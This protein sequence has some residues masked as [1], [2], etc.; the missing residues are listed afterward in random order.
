M[1]VLWLLFIVITLIVVGLTSYLVSTRNSDRKIRNREDPILLAASV[2]ATIA[3]AAAAWAA[4]ATLDAIKTIAAKERRLDRPYILAEVLHALAT[5]PRNPDDS[6]AHAFNYSISAKIR[7]TNIGRRDAAD[8]VARARIF[9]LRG[10]ALDFLFS[11]ENTVGLGHRS[12]LQ[13]HSLAPGA[14]HRPERAGR[15]SMISASEHTGGVFIFA[16]CVEYGDAADNA[17]YRN[18]Q[19]FP[20]WTGD[21]FDDYFPNY[22]TSKN[23]EYRLQVAGASRKEKAVTERAPALYEFRDNC[24][25]ED[26]VEMLPDRYLRFATPS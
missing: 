20:L 13:I 8:I 11:E 18:V 24:P 7:F 26:D 5:I 2:S 25:E 19:L 9:T 6:P 15:S 3:A 12:G 23:K 16:V 4:F 1:I 22:G 10:S 14:R 17:S 21:L